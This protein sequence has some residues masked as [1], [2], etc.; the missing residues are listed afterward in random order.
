MGDGVKSSNIFDLIAEKIETVGLVGSDGVDVD[1]AAS[2]GVVTRGFAERFRIVVELVKLGQEIGKRIGVA[3]VEG[4]FGL[5]K[6][7]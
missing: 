6:S 4:E 2:H 5:G 1:Q 7:L 3:A